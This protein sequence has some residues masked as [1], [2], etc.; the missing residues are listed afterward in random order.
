MLCP[1]EICDLTSFVNTVAEV[2]GVRS[3]TAREN[4]FSALFSF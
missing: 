2:G 4:A 1:V 3:E